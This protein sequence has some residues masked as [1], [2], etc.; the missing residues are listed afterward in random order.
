MMSSDRGMNT[1]VYTLSLGV[2]SSIMAR[3]RYF[4]HTMHGGPQGA[5]CVVWHCLPRSH[6]SPSGGCPAYIPSCGGIVHCCI[7]PLFPLL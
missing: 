2:I 4:P 7:A 3:R 5:H 1:V 6:P